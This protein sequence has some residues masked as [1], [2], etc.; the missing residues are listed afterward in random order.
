MAL[1][2]TL[3]IACARTVDARLHQ[4]GQANCFVEDL[5]QAPIDVP[6]PPR[7]PR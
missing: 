5:G 3:T 1:R 4:A 6:Y 7:L 2:R